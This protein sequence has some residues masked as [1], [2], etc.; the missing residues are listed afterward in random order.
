MAQRSKRQVSP[1][2]ASP[3]ENYE[4]DLEINSFNTKELKLKNLSFTKAR[5]MLNQAIQQL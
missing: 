1:E 2:K 4:L 3:V 5:Q